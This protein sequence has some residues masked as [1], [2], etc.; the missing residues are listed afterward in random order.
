[1][2]D[3]AFTASPLLKHSGNFVATLQKCA[4]PALE[5]IGLNHSTGLTDRLW[6]NS[7]S[8]LKVSLADSPKSGLDDFS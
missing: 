6:S 1:M 5:N 2:Q 3:T 8:D 4:L 7:K